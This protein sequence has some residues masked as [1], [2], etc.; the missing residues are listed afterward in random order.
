MDIKVKC[1]TKY[2][3]KSDEAHLQLQCVN[4]LNN[5]MMIYNDQ[6]I[7]SCVILLLQLC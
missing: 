3:Q 5:V 4:V 6:I 2:A 1:A 7:T